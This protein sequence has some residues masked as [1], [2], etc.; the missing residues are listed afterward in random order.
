VTNPLT[1]VLELAEYADHTATFETRTELTYAEGGSDGITVRL[2][3]RNWHA[4]GRPTQ[5]TVT[6]TVETQP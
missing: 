4:L 3:F 2:A 5:I 1:R 6:Y